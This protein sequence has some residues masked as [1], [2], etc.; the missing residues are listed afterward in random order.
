MLAEFGGIA[1]G[2]WWLIGTGIF[3]VV[4]CTLFGLAHASNARRRREAI[5]EQKRIRD[6][7]NWG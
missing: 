1:N 6:R 2:V 3:A 4:G 5:R 7:E